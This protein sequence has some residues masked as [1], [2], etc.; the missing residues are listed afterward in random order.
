MSASFIYCRGIYWGALFLLLALFTESFAQP[1]PLE[2]AVIAVPSPRAEHAA[3]F[4]CPGTGII[5][6]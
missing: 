1:V 4:F 2:K 3:G 5:Q 6:E